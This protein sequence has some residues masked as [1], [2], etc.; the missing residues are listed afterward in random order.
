M[1]LKRKL[2]CSGSKMKVFARHWLPVNGDG[3]PCMP[4]W[5]VLLE[6]DESHILFGPLLANGVVAPFFQLLTS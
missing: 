6:L 5:Q 1:F 3:G 4:P 2:V